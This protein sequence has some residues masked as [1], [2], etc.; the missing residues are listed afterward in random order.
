MMLVAVLSGFGLSLTAPW[1]HRLGRG[2]T[3]WL[4]ALLPLSL[5][6]YFATLVPQVAAG[7]T[8]TVSYPWAPSLGV[9]LSFAVDGLSLLF[10]LLIS[11]IGTLVIIYAGG[12]LAGHAQLGRF[13]TYILMFMAA[14]L[15]LVLAN[16][17]ITLYVFWELTTVSSYLLIGFKHDSEKAR[18]AAQQSLLVTGAGGLAL[19][20]GLIMLGQA[21]GSL[22]LSE[23]AMRGD[24]ITAHPLYMGILVCI[25]LGAF[26]KS[27]QFPFHFWLPGAMEAPAPVSS[28]LHSATMV[29]AGVYLLAR[30]SPAIGGTPAW[31]MTLSTVGA[32]TLLLGA[33]LALQQ[34]DLKRLLAYST[35]S[36]LGTLVLLIGIGTSYAIT[37]A[38]MFLLAHALYKGALFMSAG[39]VD[40][41]TGTRDVLSL[42]GLRRAMPIVWVAAG[43]AALSMAGMF[44]FSGFIGKELAY[45][46]LL[47]SPLWG[48]ALTT[49]AVLGNVLMVLVAGVVWVKPFFGPPVETPK[50]VHEAPISM[51]LGPVLLAG[52]GLIAGLLPSTAQPLVLPATVAA[53]GEPYEYTLVL[54]PGI[55]LALILS[56]I[57]V[58]LGVVAYL[59]RNTLRETTVR[60]ARVASWGPER[61]YQQ[62]LDGLNWI[63]TTQTQL[64]QS[65]YLRVYVII[66]MAISVAL[67]AFTAVDRVAI[68]LPSTAL[69]IR[70]Y[71]IAIALAILAGAF[72]MTRATS[73]LAAVA[74]LGVVGYG[75]ALIF[76]LYSGPDLAMT[77]F[78]VETLSVILFVLVLYR[79]PRFVSFSSRPTRIRDILIAF[80]VGTMMTL[81][82]LAAIA[83]PFQ[84]QLAN[85]FNENSVPLGNG[86]NIVNVIL[87]DFR[88][89]DTLGEITVLAMA[90]IG[91]YALLAL[92]PELE[93]RLQR[94]EVETAQT[95]KLAVPQ[96]VA[97]SD[98]PLIS[99]ILSTTAQ[100]LLPLMLIF[101]VFM[102]LR[103]HNEPG[104]GFVG[105]LVA[106]AAFALYA[107]THG[108]NA[109]QRALRVDP[110]TLIAVGLLVAVGS[111]MLAFFVGQPFMAGLWIPDPLPVIGKAGTPVLFDVGVYIT[112]MGVALTM[113]FA[114]AEE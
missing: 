28:Y 50:H 82:T 108:K 22:E 3:G 40:H 101:S 13:Y 8:L 110:R 88:G 21:G 104:G 111:G 46:A 55:N 79:L 12:Y 69:D 78:A 38:M 70:I 19:L 76:M 43:L 91:V 61:G 15:G 100:A 23:L 102:L 6:A 10:A 16:N 18:K 107:I 39:V 84:S 29:K 65:G 58:A 25:L 51:W 105:G 35:V 64:L 17:L 66:I 71:E 94:P 63:A 44:P 106:A 5:T 37:A 96:A 47:D 48:T 73:R 20:P 59:G 42:G 60:L 89:F 54:W 68:P 57:T 56:V 34:T 7:Q 41:E 85:S 99:L 11:G 95:G 75:V 90:A 93:G 72:T 97:Q 31:Q 24:T 26:T 53:L 2:A 36:A 52:L 98:E 80:T 86:R 67:V 4:I 109:A 14:M 74:S 92:R 32:A 33:Y 114:M 27:A 49:V 77:Q 113:I 87:V 62:S 1:L 112:V 45:V 81:L 103:G 9:S 83:T 30:L